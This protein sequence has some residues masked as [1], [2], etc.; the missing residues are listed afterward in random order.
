M[1]TLSK[2][3]LTHTRMNKNIIKQEMPELRKYIFTLLEFEDYTRYNG[4]SHLPVCSSTPPSSFSRS[5]LPILHS[6]NGQQGT[7]IT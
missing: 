7:K 6:F 2:L 1:I 3:V 4:F 5:L